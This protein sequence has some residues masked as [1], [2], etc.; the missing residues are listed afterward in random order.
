MFEKE[1]DK[2]VQE[3][4]ESVQEEFEKKLRNIS[5]QRNIERSTK[6]NSL[7]LEKMNERDKLIQ[8]LLTESKEH[9]S[10]TLAD[11]AN[12]KYARTLQQLIVQ[13]STARA[14]AHCAEH[15]QAAG[16]R[17][18]DQVPR[19]G[20]RPDQLDGQGL[21]GGVL[22]HYE[23]GDQARLQLQAHCAH[24]R[25]LR[26]GSRGQVSSRA[27]LN[28]QMRRHSHDDDEQTHCLLKYIGEPA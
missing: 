3:E 27:R 9:L 8:R 20:P 6:I 2:M 15:D 10:Q 4:V 26:P 24:R 1:R 22:E 25:V 28:A 7:R 11:P 13:V 19:D 18:P 5:M 17:D 14:I 12:P 16:E 21:R 23:V